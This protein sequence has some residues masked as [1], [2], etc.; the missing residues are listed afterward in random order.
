M[1]MR[2][3]SVNARPSC[4]SSA[5]ESRADAATAAQSQSRGAGVETGAAWLGQRVTQVRSAGRC[6]ET[7]ACSREDGYRLGSYERLLRDH[8]ERLKERLSGEAAGRIVVE[9]AENDDPVA[10]RFLDDLTVV[11]ALCRAL[12]LGL[13]SETLN[14]SD[15]WARVAVSCE[16]LQNFRNLRTEVDS[17]CKP[18]VRM[19]RVKGSAVRREQEF[20]DAQRKVVQN[21]LQLGAFTAPAQGISG[22]ETP[23]QRLASLLAAYTTGI[24]DAPVSSRVQD[25]E[26][27]LDAADGALHSMASALL[28]VSRDVGLNR[29]DWSQ[30]DQGLRSRLSEKTRAYLHRRGDVGKGLIECADRGDVMARDFLSDVTVMV[31]ARLA[32]ARE[33]H[34]LKEL[35]FI[36]PNRLERYVA[37]IGRIGARMRGLCRIMAEILANHGSGGEG[38]NLASYR[39]SL[40]IMAEELLALAESIWKVMGRDLKG[41][42][43]A[44]CLFDLVQG[45]IASRYGAAPDKGDSRRALTFD[46]QARN[47]HRDECAKLSR[48]GG[49]YSFT[50]VTEPVIKA[51]THLQA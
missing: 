15:G 28:G 32:L 44:V 13:A 45:R 22:S 10:S 18:M 2:G 47:R 16:E 27:D 4:A 38:T 34:R 50:H 17:L 19:L 46:V 30:V 49:E 35:G 31:T 9:A 33:C 12:E 43:P 6:M 7:R 51:L 11:D 24:L 23:T 5:R 39:Q 29:S 21:F 26:I 8:S 40:G 25:A 48:P 14:D 3:S 20:R 41:G 42:S 37:R 1:D 36:S